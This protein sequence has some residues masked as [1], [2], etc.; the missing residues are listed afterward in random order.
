[1]SPRGQDRREERAIYRALR[2]GPLWELDG[3]STGGQTAGPS[4]STFGRALGGSR[5]P[6]LLIRSQMLYPLSYERWYSEIQCTLPP[7]S[8]CSALRPG[9]SVPSAVGALWR[10]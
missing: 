8:R 5:T 10:V 4:I 1:M 7:P 2:D 3:R 6:N 9:L